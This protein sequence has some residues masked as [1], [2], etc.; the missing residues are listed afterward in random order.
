LTLSVSPVGEEMRRPS[1]PSE[2]GSVFGQTLGRGHDN[3]WPRC[4]WRWSVLLGPSGRASHL[5]C[6]A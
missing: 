6:S 4:G 2:H 5:R 3:R 1:L